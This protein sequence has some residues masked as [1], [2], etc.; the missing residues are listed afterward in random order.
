MGAES[1]PVWAT[2]NFE[3]RPLNKISSGDENEPDPGKKY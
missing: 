1:M 3:N 2:H